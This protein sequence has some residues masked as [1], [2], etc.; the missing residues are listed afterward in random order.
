MPIG[1]SRW[2]V[3]NFPGRRIY[4]VFVCPKVGAQFLHHQLWVKTRSMKSRASRYQLLA[5][6][7]SMKR[8][9]FD[10]QNALKTKPAKAG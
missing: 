7:R 5:E 6:A 10:F 9:F 8:K 3:T 1:F 4:S 2:L